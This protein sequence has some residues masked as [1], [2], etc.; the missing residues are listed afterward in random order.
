MRIK[1]I[2][3]AI[4]G[5]DADGGFFICVH[6]TAV[7]CYIGTENRGELAFHTFLLRYLFFYFG[8]GL[9]RTESQTAE[10]RFGIVQLINKKWTVTLIPCPILSA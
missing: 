10:K 2:P 6:E 9:D 4:G 7:A 3:L 1:K 5:E 8:G